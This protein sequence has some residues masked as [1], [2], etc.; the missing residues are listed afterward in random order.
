LLRARGG[1]L[2]ER[3]RWEGGGGGGGIKG[4]GDDARVCA[5]RGAPHARHRADA[6]GRPSPVR[7]RRPGAARAARRAHEGADSTVSGSR[8]TQ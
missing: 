3:R 2:R 6:L 7:Q 4:K 8:G 5:Q 1:E